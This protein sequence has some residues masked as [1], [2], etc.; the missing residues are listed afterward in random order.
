MKTGDNTYL[1]LFEHWKKIFAVA[2]GME[3]PLRHRDVLLVREH[4]L[5]GVLRT[6]RPSRGAA[7]KRLWDHA[8]FGGSRVA[9]LCQGIALGAL[10]RGSL[11]ARISSFA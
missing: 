10:V 3:G 4:Q 1:A 7:Q 9:A 8:F 6:R 5:V 11:Q 2:F